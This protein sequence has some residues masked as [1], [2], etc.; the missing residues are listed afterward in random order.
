[1]TGSWKQIREFVAALAVTLIGALPT[2][3]AEVPRPSIDTARAVAKAISMLPVSLVGTSI[4][5]DLVSQAD[6]E[7]LQPSSAVILWLPDQRKVRLLAG[8]PLPSLEGAVRMLA[9]RQEAAVFLDRIASD[10]PNLTEGRWVLVS[11]GSFEVPASMRRETAP[12]VSKS[13]AVPG[14]QPD[15]VVFN[16]PFSPSTFG[17]NWFAS[18]WGITSCNA[19]GGTYSAGLSV[20]TSNC[21]ATY[22]AN[23]SPLMVRNGCD[24]VTGA[25]AASVTAYY[26]INS[27]SGSDLLYVGV[28]LTAGGGYYSGPAISGNYPGVWSALNIDLKS[29]TTTA[30]NIDVT[31]RPCTNLAVG[32]N[33]NGSISY[34]FGARVDDITISST[35]GGG[36][37]GGGGA[38]CTPSASTLCL[39]SNRF[40]VKAT[41]DS[42]GSP[43]VYSVASATSVSDNTG[44]FTTATAGNVDVI[45]KMVNFCSSN[46]TWSAY[47]GGTTDLGVRIAI[48]DKS[49]G[50]VYNASNPLGSGWVLI[51]DAAFTCP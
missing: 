21:N 23:A 4:E 44:Y 15:T 29:V 46:N 2:A 47:I 39:F 40:E 42:Y 12:A 22:L 24:S 33:S 51:R 11:P 9:G 50:S 45:V 17:T 38:T 35:G 13:P 8:G 3:A 18:G 48:T 28:P 32:F 19:H 37:G 41:Y 14:P 5:I 36:G 20:A 43:S 16:E 49:T 7:R 6:F 26:E 1:M 10:F 27:Q 30:G 25:T 31:A 34:A